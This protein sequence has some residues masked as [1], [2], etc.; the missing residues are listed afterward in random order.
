MTQ[1]V[2]LCSVCL[3][4]TPMCLILKLTGT[5][6]EMWVASRSPRTLQNPPLIGSTWRWK[7]CCQHCVCS[8]GA[9]QNVLSWPHAC[10]T[11]LSHPTVLPS[12][13]K[14]LV[15]MPLLQRQA[16]ASYKSS[17][18]PD[19][20]KT[21][22]CYLKCLHEQAHIHI[23]GHCCSVLGLHTHTHTCLVG[24]VTSPTVQEA[25]AFLSSCA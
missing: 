25:N 15:A 1:Q 16:L 12:V 5:K 9:L 13:E 23:A 11:L 4:P 6:P 3:P 24:R 8:S 2:S 20:G 10:N 19:Q 18:Q 22:G 21:G 17:S 14:A 7:S